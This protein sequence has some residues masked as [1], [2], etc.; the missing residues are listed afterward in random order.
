MLPLAIVA[1]LL[2]TGALSSQDAVPNEDEILV[3]SEPLLPSSIVSVL[4]DSFM[5]APSVAPI[6]PGGCATSFAGPVE[7]AARTAP[8][9]IITVDN[10]SCA[11]ASF[12]AVTGEQLPGIDAESGLVIIGG[13]GLEFDWNSL[14]AQCLGEETRSADGCREEANLARATASNSFFS[15]RSLLQQAHRQAPDATIVVVAPPVPVSTRPLVLGSACCGSSTDANGQVRAVFDTAGSLRRAVAES[16]PEIPVLVIETDVVFEGHRIDDDANWLVSKAN[17]VGSPNRLGV[18]AIA[19][20]IDALMPVGLPPTEAPVA[21]AEVVLVLGTT[22]DDQPALDAISADAAAWFDRFSAAAVSPSV[23]IVP[24]AAT[25]PPTTATTAAPPT[26]TTTAAPP[27]TTT[28]APTT[29]TTAAPTT[30]TTAAPAVPIVAPS[31]A[32]AEQ[33]SQAL[34]ELEIT[35]GI[36]T[37]QELGAA[38]ETAT[39]LLTPTVTDATIVVRAQNLTIDLASQDVVNAIR[40]T[41]FEAGAKVII[42]VD[43]VRFAAALSNVLTDSGAAIG[44]TPTNEL[45]RSLPAPKAQQTLQEL[46][47]PKAVEGVVGQ[48][49]PFELAV[50]A[51]KQ[52]SA[53]VTWF[54]D[55]IAVG[56]GQRAVLNTASLAEGTH[57]GRVTVDGQTETLEAPFTLTMTRDGDGRDD[58]QLCGTAFDPL[59]IDVDG[60]DLPAECDSD[61]DGDG[62]PDDLDPCRSDATNDLRDLDLDGLPDHCDAD[63][64][65]GPGAD[66]DGDGFP[67][68]IDNCPSVSQVNQFDQDDDGLGN[69]CEGRISPACTIIG[70]QGNDRLNGTNGPDVICGLGGN[71]VITTLAG[72]DIVFGG[73]GDD[74]IHGGVDADRLYGGAGNDR[75]FGNGAAD[76]LIGG[77]GN[78]EIRGGFGADVAFGGRGADTLLGDAG[79]DVLFGGR[80]AD[81]LRGG[82]GRDTLAGDRGA[83]TIFGEDGADLISGGPGNDTLGGGRGD[84]V[85]IDVSSTD[86]ARGGSGLDI[87]DAAPIRVS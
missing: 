16:V 59:P 49:V 72:E 31:Y 33:L 69:A 61:D 76:V 77:P 38:I 81:L 15:W 87:I 55:D 67:N 9:T 78:D 35:D 12:Q 80:G 48:N 83:D 44:L 73:D 82:P 51:T 25:A 19:E 29:T 21:P 58:A 79:S 37:L 13:I 28:T 50:R 43:D 30:T 24:L 18:A 40:R 27:T 8:E 2:S 68:L 46:I 34:A 86:F 47:F 36:S 32:S 84:D 26:T 4:G 53:A 66:T 20:L 11:N 63:P 39:N 57:I 42:L 70:T 5:A 60:D 56:S 22:P 1:S 62:L 41:V 64:D 75:L 85:L 65:D 10:R 71:D 14:A 3:V 54:I 74:Q 7:L 23:A 17:M 45:G 52:T 6:R